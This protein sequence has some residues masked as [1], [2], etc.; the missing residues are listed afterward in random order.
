M[1]PN[2]GSAGASPTGGLI[3]IS[4]FFLNAMKWCKNAQIKSKLLAKVG[5]FNIIFQKTRAQ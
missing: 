4:L 2:L 5:V 3:F 1:T